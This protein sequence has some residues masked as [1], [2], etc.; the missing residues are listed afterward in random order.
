MLKL[1]IKNHQYYLDK[2]PDTKIARLC[3]GDAYGSMFYD[4]FCQTEL[5]KQ[6]LISGGLF[7]EC[8]IDPKKYLEDYFGIDL[9]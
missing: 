5:E 6:N 3:K 1:Y 2:H 8:G 4:L 9:A 7:P